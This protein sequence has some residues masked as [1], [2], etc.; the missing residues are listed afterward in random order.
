MDCSEFIAWLGQ[1]TQIPD[2]TGQITFHQWAQEHGHP[3]DSQH[4]KLFVDFISEN[5]FGTIDNASTEM[6]VVEV[7]HNIPLVLTAKNPSR[8]FLTSIHIDAYQPIELKAFTVKRLAL[9][10]SGGIP[11]ILSNL[12]IDTLEIS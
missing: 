6:V 5:L 8:N 7:L 10:G 9:H 4:W 2:K 1:T 12:S 11:F 3:A